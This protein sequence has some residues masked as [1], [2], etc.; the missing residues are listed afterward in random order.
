MLDVS[1]AN[2]FSAGLLPGSWLQSLTPYFH[3]LGFIGFAGATLYFILE[4]SNLA[5]EFRVIASLNA[6]VA[7]ITV[8]GY[9]HLAGLGGA[10]LPFT[11][12]GTQL[13][14]MDWLITLP[15]MLLQIPVLLGMDR[16]SRGLVVRMVLAAIVMVAVGMVGECLL[17]APTASALS[18]NMVFTLYG[19]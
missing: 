2:I 6:V 19:I 14:Y 11:A 3:W 16:S 17:S 10:K 18:I 8:I 12:A 1:I 4:R 15:L 13:R 7:L 5:P 9:Y